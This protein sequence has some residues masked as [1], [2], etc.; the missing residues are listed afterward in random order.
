MMMQKKERGSALVAV[1]GLIFTAGV[2]C[3][4]IIALS[5][6]GTFEI[7]PHVSRQRSMYILEGAGNRIQWLLAADRYLN[8]DVTLGELDYEEFDYE[9]YVAD[10]VA[11]VISS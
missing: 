6:T 8:S 11:H 5:R 2:L 1:L 4:A 9:R 10:G 3:A 7:M